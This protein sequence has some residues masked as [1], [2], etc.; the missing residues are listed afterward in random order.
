MILK[1]NNEQKRVLKF[2]RGLYAHS[3]PPTTPP[4]PPPLFPGMQ[5]VQVLSN[6]STATT[7]NETTTK[8]FTMLGHS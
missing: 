4:P 5:L 8:L 7:T 1:H 3:T 2:R 6:F